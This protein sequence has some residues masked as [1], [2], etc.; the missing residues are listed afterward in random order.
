[1]LPT[2][3]SELPQ[4]KRNF[5]MSA[6]CRTLFDQAADTDAS[7]LPNSQHC[8][9]L[10]TT[11]IKPSGYTRNRLFSNMI[12]GKVSVFND[13]P[14]PYRMPHHSVQQRSE[15]IAD[16]ISAIRITNKVRTRIGTSRRWNYFTPTELI[17]RWKNGAAAANVTDFH[18]RDTSL[19]KLINPT[20]LSQ[21]NL[22]PAMSAE[23][24]W[25][26]MMTMV[27]SSKGGFSDSHSDDC[28]GSNH[29]F[30]GTKLWLAWDT[31]EGL[32]NGLEDLDQQN[33]S[34]RCAFDLDA[35][36]SL[37][38]ACW[39]TVE[40]GQTLFMPG[41]LSHKVVTLDQYLGV[42]SF[43]ISFANI[44]RTLARWQLVK[45]N[46]QRLEAK[47]LEQIVYREVV[48]TA[49]NRRNMVSKTSLGNQQKWG[50]DYLGKSWRSMKRS[51][52][53]SDLSRLQK[54]RN[55]DRLIGS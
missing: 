31:R 24:S 35:F 13:F 34:G 27:V 50:L 25:I 18:L 41:H 3:L 36:L 8:T 20:V 1:M 22:L 10:E 38:S 45:P 33:I 47:S 23:V 14:S 37:K 44:L 46:W 4:P 12:N 26:E 42:G 16:A 48:S 55:I 11:R 6:N 15:N 29:C 2:G 9:A 7:L 53:S 19:E 5:R 28:D 51:N 39:F 43:Y 54:I 40:T 32:K 17:R 52:L 21:F 30:T 49:L